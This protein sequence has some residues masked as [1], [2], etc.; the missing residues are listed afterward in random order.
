MLI[1]VNNSYMGRL[2]SFVSLNTGDYNLARTF[3]QLVMSVL[4]ILLSS[5]FGKR[6][7]F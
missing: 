3:D 6:W 5:C 7:I 2:D 4:V 1:A